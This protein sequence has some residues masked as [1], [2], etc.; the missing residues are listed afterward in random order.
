M[1]QAAL[2]EHLIGNLGVSAEELV[3][4]RRPSGRGVGMGMG[5]SDEDGYGPGGAE[6]EEDGQQ[7]KAATGR[8]YAAISY[9]N[10]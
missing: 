9:N 3:A 5:R 10:K 6:E 1:Q 2:R 8:S 7:V 4:P